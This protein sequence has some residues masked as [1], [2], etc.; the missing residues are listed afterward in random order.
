MPNNAVTGITQDVQGYIWVSTWWGIA[1]FDG[2]KFD[3]IVDALPGG[4]VFCIE[5]DHRGRIWVGTD[6]GVA[7]RED[8]VWKRPPQ[9]PA[10]PV[11]ALQETADGTMWAGGYYHSWKIS[12]SSKGTVEMDFPQS[13]PHIRA[14][15]ADGEGGMWLLGRTQLF[16]CKADGAPVAVPGPWTGQELD[17]LGYDRDQRLVVCGNGI[18]VR[19]DGAEWTDLLPLIPGSQADTFNA[20]TTGPDGTLWL[21]TRNAGL[22]YLN[23]E[24]HGR[25]DAPT[26]LS[27]ND[28]RC[29]FFDRQGT[30]WVGT[31]GGGLDRLR[32]R[33][34]DSYG[35]AEGLGRNVTSAI[36]IGPDGVVRVGTDGSGIFRKDEDRFVPDLRDAG[37]PERAPIWSMTYDPQGNLWVGFEREELFRVRDG[38]AEPV[39]G[40]F[41]TQANESPTLFHSLKPARDGGLLLGMSYHGLRKLEGGTCRTLLERPYVG[42]VSHTLEDSRGRLWA[43]AGGEGV[44]VFENDAWR[45]VRKE[46]AVKNFSPGILAEAADGGVWIGS[47]G[48]GLVL[49]RD[50]HVK[51]WGKKEGL[52]SLAIFQMEVDDHGHL[53]LG[54]DQGLQRLDIAE[55]ER[56]PGNDGL[57]LHSLRFNRTDGLPPGQFTVAHGNASLKAPDGSLWFSLAGGAIHVDPTVTLRAPEAPQVHVESASDSR[58]PFWQFE[59]P[60]QHDRIVQ[61]P[62]SG[63]LL[64]R[65]TAPEFVRPEEL[66]FRYRLSGLEKDW[67]ESGGDRTAGYPLLPPGEYRFEVAVSTPE[68][69]WSARPASVMVVVQPFFW[70]TAAF[71]IAIVAVAL[72]GAGILVRKWSER[73]LKRKM[74]RLMQETR[75]ERERTRIAGDLHDDL[76]ATLS[77]I[78]FIGTFAADTFSN[79]PVR[80]SLENIVDRAQRMAKSLDE[81]VWTVNP[82]H[83]HLPSVARYLCSRCQESLGTAGIRCRL[84]VAEGL[85][86][87]PLDSQLRH[88]LLMAV[89]EIIHNVMKHS[90]AT[91]CTLAIRLEKHELVIRVTDDGRGFDRSE[92]PVDRNGLANLERRMQEIQGGFDITSTPGQGTT[93][94]LRAPLPS[95]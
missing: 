38:K 15:R 72:L 5:R 6:A 43:A 31:N 60:A 81:I 32:R 18:L 63:R 94:T 85:P 26:S 3:N 42:S 93:V 44:W 64:I 78:N 65:F 21:A 58:G 19:K 82:A 62:G 7:W 28:T 69:G 36:A 2:V 55:L 88:H 67:R 17:G 35:P 9:I 70:Q 66:R 92:C 33:T 10:D 90:G 4:T 56:S 40:V 91:G 29:V 48:E 71:R 76:G 22:V 41:Q 87:V 52:I 75:L 95:S 39:P 30:L 77:E 25:I 11:Y 34:F 53:W 83:D 80:Q 49:W 57:P 14:L 20:C 54:T 59:N 61:P 50:G 1:R 16:H 46:I 8:G 74:A 27:L 24:T 68:G 37:L 51:W 47:F 89:N 13:S 12:N 79:H 84:D 23:G 73:R 86:D 45:D